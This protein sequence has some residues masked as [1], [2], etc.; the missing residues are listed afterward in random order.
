[1]AIFGK[2][3]HMV[4]SAKNINERRLLPRRFEILGIV[5]DHKQ[6]SFDFI[7]RRF[8]G[9]PSRTLR[10]DLNKLCKSGFIIKRG[11][12]RGAVYEAW[13]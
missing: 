4:S 7:K 12:T 5:R 8:W 1:L 2:L 3:K 13:E 11:V 6:V 9:V 10:Y